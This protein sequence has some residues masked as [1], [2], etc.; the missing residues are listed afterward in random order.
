MI[1]NVIIS[2]HRAVKKLNFLSHPFGLTAPSPLK[3]P[4]ISIRVPV[5]INTSAISSEH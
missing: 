1:K 3:G 2:K 4:F 5:F